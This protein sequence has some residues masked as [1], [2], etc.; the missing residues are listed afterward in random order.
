MPDVVLGFL[1]A[2]AAALLFS[3]GTVLQA[4]DAKQ[5]DHDLALTPGLIARLV[6]RRRW[7]AGTALALAGWPLQVVAL[8]LT[9][10]TVVQPT[11][12]IGILVLLAAGHRALGEPIGAREWLAA[13]AIG[14]G[15]AG[16]VIAAPDRSTDVAGP[17]IV[18]VVFAI[19]LIVVLAPFVRRPGHPPRQLLVVLSA[20]TGYA[21]TGL[22]TK[23][24]GDAITEEVWLLA[25]MWLALTGIVAMFGLMSDMTSLQRWPA[26]RVA[27]ITFALETVVPVALA[28]ALTDE[29]VRDLPGD[30]LPLLLAIALVT[31]GAVMLGRSKAVAAMY[32]ADSG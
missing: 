8:Q 4:L 13:L 10:I 14:V 16:A 17:V 5:Q 11:L 28:P 6:R 9:S 2:L 32:E 12:M 30:G 29:T 15:V 24:L 19:L 7:L 18:T 20:G 26:T 22:S 31:A 27:P 1:A 3:G 21:F 23:F 25:G